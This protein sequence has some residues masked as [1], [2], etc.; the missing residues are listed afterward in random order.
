MICFCSLF[1]PKNRSAKSGRC[2]DSAGGAGA[3]SLRCR[4]CDKA[5]LGLEVLAS[6]LR[7]SEKKKKKKSKKVELRR[8]KPHLVLLHFARLLSVTSV[9]QRPESLVFYFNLCTVLG[10]VEVW[11]LGEGFLRPRGSVCWWAMSHMGAGRGAHPAHARQRLAQPRARRVA[12]RGSRWA[13]GGRGCPRT[14]CQV[15]GSLTPLT[16]HGEVGHETA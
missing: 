16:T 7:A 14:R 3:G 8:E 2:W 15:W 11:Q 13:F 12:W 1:N 5:A 10:F 6:V 9:E 4:T